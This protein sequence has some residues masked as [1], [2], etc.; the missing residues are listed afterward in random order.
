MTREEEIAA[1][2][3]LIKQQAALLVAYEETNAVS[4]EEAQFVTPLDLLKSKNYTTREV[5]DSRYAICKGCDEFWK[6]VKVCKECG[7][8]MPMK[9]WLKEA[10]CPIG[11]W[12]STESGKGD[13]SALPENKEKEIS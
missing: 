1:E 10:R 6:T 4:D 2:Q 3:E 9:T 11:K 8:S 12:G 13:V 7:C 5:R